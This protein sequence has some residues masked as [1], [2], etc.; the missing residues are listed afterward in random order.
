MKGSF[1]YNAE[2]DF[3]GGLPSS[4]VTYI[5]RHHNYETSTVEA[6]WSYLGSDVRSAVKGD[7]G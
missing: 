6:M 1:S 4:L 5:D 7:V 2:Y 3:K